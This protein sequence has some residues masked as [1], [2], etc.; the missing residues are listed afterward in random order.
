MS[1]SQ[2]L[3]AEADKGERGNYGIGTSTIALLREAAAILEAAEAWY[4]AHT[5]E[6]IASPTSQQAYDH[7][8][9]DERGR[10]AADAALLKALAP[11]SGGDR[12]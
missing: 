8:V 7:A 12:L 5:A 11:A 6:N 3:K 1:L 4:L 9:A 2:R 10:D